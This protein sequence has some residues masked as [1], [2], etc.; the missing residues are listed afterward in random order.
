MVQLNE[1]QRRDA[2][3]RGWA[4]AQQARPPRPRQPILY[5]I[6]YFEARNG[7]PQRFITDVEQAA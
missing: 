3:Q 1:Q 4:D 2:Y 7:A 5:Q 6:G